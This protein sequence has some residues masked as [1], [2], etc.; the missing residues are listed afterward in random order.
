MKIY[1]IRH[2]QT[3][4]NALGRYI[5]RTDEPLSKEGLAKAHLLTPDTH[6]SSVFVTPLR[7]TQQTARVL[8]PNAEQTIVPDLREMDFG[9]FENRSAAEMENDADYRAWVEG[10]CTAP[11]PDGEGMAGFAERVGRCFYKLVRNAAAEGRESVRIVAHGG[12]LMAV[13]SL[14]AED[15]QPY[16]SYGADNLTGWEATARFEGDTLTLTGLMRFRP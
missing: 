5:G 16:Y 14:F 6:V 9:A 15:K 4:G 3:P 11:C 10:G 7:R 1:L 13:L 12:T 2:G 8:F